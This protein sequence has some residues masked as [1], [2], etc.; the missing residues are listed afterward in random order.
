[1]TMPENAHL[2]TC[3][4]KRKKKPPMRKPGEHFV[5]LGYLLFD[6]E[7]QIGKSTSHVAQNFFQALQTWTLAGKWNLLQDV[8]PD[9]LASWI[10]PLLMETRYNIGD[11]KEQAPPRVSHCGPCCA[12]RFKLRDSRRFYESKKRAKDPSV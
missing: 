7:M 4:W 2:T 10:F 11:A 6:G 3:R 5:A 1:M 8:L 12:F 9:E